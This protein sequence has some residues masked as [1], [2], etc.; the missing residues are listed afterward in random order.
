MAYARSLST[1]LHTNVQHYEELKT[2]MQDIAKEVNELKAIELDG[3]SYG[4]ELFLGG[5]WKFLALVCG[6]KAANADFSCIWC[7]CHAH[8]HGL[9][10]VRC[11]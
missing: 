11:F 8:G 3:E 2:G 1:F 5:D 4:V 6:L 10:F 7:K 9:V